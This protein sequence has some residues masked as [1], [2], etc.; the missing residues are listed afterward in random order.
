MV[1]VG[2]TLWTRCI[3]RSIGFRDLG[4]GSKVT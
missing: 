2:D 1:R 4:A 3:D